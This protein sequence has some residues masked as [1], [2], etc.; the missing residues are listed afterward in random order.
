MAKKPASEVEPAEKSLDREVFNL[1][2][3]Q[4]RALLKDLANP[5]P[6]NE[7]LTTLMK[8]TPPWEERSRSE[9]LFGMLEREEQRPVPIEKMNEAVGEQATE[10]DE[11]IKKS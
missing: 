7:A 5:P 4:T 2:A 10:D 8:R 9:N 3:E 11:R 6:A 1:D